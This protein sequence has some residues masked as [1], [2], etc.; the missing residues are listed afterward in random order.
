MRQAYS[1]FA[2]LVVTLCVSA[3]PPSVHASSGTEGAGF[4]DIPVGAGPAAMGSAYSALATDA[5]APTWNPAGLGFLDS[6]QVAAQHLSYVQSTYYEYLSFGVPMTRPRSCTSDFWCGTSAL[7]GSIQYLGSG[8]IPGSDANGNPTGS[9]SAQ[10][11]AYNLAYGRVF[12]DRLSLGLAGKFLD[13]KLA[14]V[15]ATAYAVDLG[16][17]YKLK[18]NLQVAATLM[19]LGRNITFLS[20]ADPLPLSM[21][22]GAAYQPFP[23]GNLA[24]E[25][26]FPRNGLASAHFGAEWLP[27][28]MFALRMGYRTDTVSG[29]SPL[30]GYSLGLGIH[31]WNHEFAYAWVPYGDLGNSHYFSLLLRFGEAHEAKRNLIKIDHSNKP[32]RVDHTGEP[33]ESNQEDEYHMLLELL[34]KTEHPPNNNPPP[35]R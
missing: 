5:Y 4:L 23:A 27:L 9:Y 20:Q 18:D 33:A 30:A 6:L 1:R 2:F 17:M 13:I 10:Y 14:D 29:L 28:P 22:L 35:S 25:G 11:A 15:T 24:A 3:P 19:N 21:H 26:V 34:Y 32:N 16:S 31:M 12:G 7:G 8:D